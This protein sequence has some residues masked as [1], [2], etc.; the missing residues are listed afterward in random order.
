MFA[1]T[2]QQSICSLIMGLF[3]FLR[4]GVLEALNCW[5]SHISL[6]HKLITRWQCLKIS[7]MLPPRWLDGETRLCA[8][9]RKGLYPSFQTAPCPPPQET[10]TL[11]KLASLRE[12]RCRVDPWGQPHSWHACDGGG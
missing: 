2:N 12:G 3:S 5:V 10:R 8:T 11:Q 1:D 7:F 4:D 6:H 9:V